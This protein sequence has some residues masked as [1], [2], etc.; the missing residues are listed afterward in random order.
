VRAILLPFGLWLL[1]TITLVF[2]Y[3]CIPNL[4]QPWVLGIIVAYL[5]LGVP[6]YAHQSIRFWQDLKALRFL[7]KAFFK[8]DIK[9]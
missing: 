1:A 5:V 6:Y 7:P 3:L 8:K 4:H 2:E 9:Q